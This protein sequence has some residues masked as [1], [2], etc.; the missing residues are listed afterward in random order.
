MNLLWRM[1]WTLLF[2]RF[3]KKVE[4]FDRCKTDFYVLPT[5][6]DVLFHMNNGRYLSIMD[7]ARTNQ[8]IRSGFF[9]KFKKARVYPVIASESIRF[10]KSLNL[11][12]RF[13]IVTKILGW[14][15]KFI[16]VSQTFKTKQDLCALAIVK[17]CF[18]DQ[19]TSKRLSSA[20]FKTKIGLNIESPSLPAWIQYWIES[21]QQH[22]NQVTEDHAKHEGKQ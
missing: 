4:L 16:Y 5:D 2:S 6:I 8:M 22:H 7:I 1:I 13:T 18:I 11:F 9:Q 15:D 3:D 12:Q 14:D 20:E 10:R 19:N 21:D 17:V